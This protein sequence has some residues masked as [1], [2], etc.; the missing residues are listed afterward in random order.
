MGYSNPFDAFGG[1]EKCGFSFSF[2]KPVLDGLTLHSFSL[3]LFRNAN[4][5]KP[6]Y[7]DGMYWDPYDAF[8][9]ILGA[10]MGYPVFRWLV[11]FAGGGLGFTWYGESVGGASFPQ[12]GLSYSDGKANDSID[13]AWKVNGGLRFKL[14]DF[15]IRAEV[16]YG[17]IIGPAFGIGVGLAL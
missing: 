14:S 3:D 7:E 13:F 9:F 8:S 12:N 2:E 5:G 15:F 10:A 11:V 16:S 6:Y 1:L 4:G 17:T